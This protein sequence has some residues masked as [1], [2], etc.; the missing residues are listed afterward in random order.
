MRRERLITAGSSLVLALLAVVLWR[1][2]LGH[3]DEV[4]RQRDAAKAQIAEIAR[5]LNTAQDPDQ[6]DRL[7]SDRSDAE[8]LYQDAARQIGDMDGWDSFEWKVKNS[9]RLAAPSG[10]I[11]LAAFTLLSILQ[12]LES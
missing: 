9:L 8:F 6:L 1:D 2:Y 3:S 10:A 7:T 4:Y 11:L 12:P 5:E